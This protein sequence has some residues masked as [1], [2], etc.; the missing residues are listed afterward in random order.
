[1]TTTVRLKSSRQHKKVIK[2]SCLN[3]KTTRRLPAPP[4]P[5]DGADRP[6][7]PESAMQ[8]DGVGVEGKKCKRPKKA[9]Y[10]Q[11]FFERPEHILFRGNEMVVKTEDPSPHETTAQASES[12]RMETDAASIQIGS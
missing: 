9:V 6:P 5:Q 1:M 8:L 12:V 3:C 7:D 10:K 4:P 11:P 2:L